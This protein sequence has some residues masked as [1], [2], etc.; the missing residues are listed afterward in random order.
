[1]TPAQHPLMQQIQKEVAET[2]RL[3]E[4]ERLAAELEATRLR[5]EQG[6]YLGRLFQEQLDQ[7][8]QARIQFHEQVGQLWASVMAYSH[9]TGV[10]PSNFPEALFNEI[11]APSLRPLGLHSLPSGFTTTQASVMNYFNSQ[12]KQWV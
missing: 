7:Y 10:H 4:Q 12:G 11:N 5:Q 9:L 6:Q 2:N 8:E 1:M 3:A